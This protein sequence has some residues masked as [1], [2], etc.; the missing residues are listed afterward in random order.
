M[1]T[2]LIVD[3][4]EGTCQ[5]LA[6][7]FGQKGYSV[8]V[9]YTG[10][11]AMQKVTRS[12][13][14][15]ALIDVRL[16]D[17][18]GVEVLRELKDV[19]PD[20]EVV[21]ITGYVSLESAIQAV[22]SK[23]FAYVQKPLDIE[24]VLAIVA[25]AVE[26]RR[27]ALENRRMLKDLT[28]LNEISAAISQTLHLEWV[29]NT[30]LDKT[31]HPLSNPGNG[32]CA[33][34]LLA[35]ALDKT[36]D[37]LEM[38]AGAILLL[39]QSR[40]SLK[41]AVSRS[42]GIG[43][44]EP[45]GVK[46]AEG[47]T[48]A[49]RAISERRPVTIEE[50]P[51]GPPL[52]HLLPADTTSIHCVAVPLMANGEVIG[53]LK[54]GG[55][56]QRL[57]N[58][59][60]LRLLTAIGQQIGVALDNA[61]LYE[62]LRAAYDQLQRTQAH[63]IQSERLSALGELVSGIAHELNN[64]L[65]VIIG[66]T[67]LM[68][69]NECSGEVKAGLQKIQKEAQRLF[70]MVNNLLTF[71]RQQQEGDWTLVDLNEVV[72]QVLELQAY[73]GRLNNIEV[74]VDL[75]PHLPRLRGDSSQLQQVVL[76]LLINAEQAIS[77]AYSSGRI[78]IRTYHTEEGR[79]RLTVEDDGPGISDS[80][81]D[82]IFDPFFTTKPAGRGTGLGL[83]ICYGIV[84]AHE[85]QIWVESEIGNGSTFI[86]EFPAVWEDQINESQPG[87]AQ[88]L[89]LPKV[90]GQGKRAL[91]VDDEPAI[92]DLLVRVL[93][94]E[95]CTVDVASD[96]SLALQLLDR[97]KYD[98]M[99][100]DFRMPGMGGQ[101]LYEMLREGRPNLQSRVVFCSGDTLNARAQKFLE[102]TGR[103]WLRKPFHIRDV[104]TVINQVL[105][106]PDD[107]SAH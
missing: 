60:D 43:H 45:Q 72:Q 14:D 82:K 66:Y 13:F 67:Q 103:P 21:M 81:K 92:T 73:G 70:R 24:H 54:L 32:Y 99:I 71:A 25:K 29:S 5:T 86:V 95:G 4:D 44:A 58:A 37:A 10:Q 28:V 84:R 68:E 17:R 51:P 22:N 36:V 39:D 64:P 93:E 96:A 42:L 102:H 11:E 78:V 88:T 61:R 94:D 1:H 12:N 77:Q 9:A 98:L 76:N 6:L 53:V 75:E 31:I 57:F 2:L 101:E 83:S 38:E 27:L 63:L 55:R 35:T 105:Q 69:A 41:I 40:S 20:L 52:A 65:T 90:A 62:G 15:V 50:A 89:N 3:D 26:R 8:E 91:V 104:R 16:P 87:T 33:T 30:A 107:E 18:D 48:A 74:L 49:W 100:F 34:G 80:I 56:G 97:T 19:A 46:L 79:L 47:G 106:P 7:V 23:A 59:H 85:G